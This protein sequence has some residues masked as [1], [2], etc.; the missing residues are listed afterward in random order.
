MHNKNSEDFVKKL[1][2]CRYCGSEM[3]GL[4]NECLICGKKTLIYKFKIVLILF[5]VLASISSLVINIYQLSVIDKNNKLYEIELKE[6]NQLIENLQGK[7]VSHGEQIQ[8]VF[9]LLYKGEA[10]LNENKENG[11]I[12]VYFK[13]DGK[14]YNLSY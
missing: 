8:E 10:T 4:K 6:K 1:V 7:M 12:T 3:R 5:L 2:Y 14:F 9:K 11:I 13:Q